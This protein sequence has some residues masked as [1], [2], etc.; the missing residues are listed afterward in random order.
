MINFGLIRSVSLATC[1]LGAIMFATAASAQDAAPPADADV[2]AESSAVAD[3]AAIIVTR[4][5]HRPLRRRRPGLA[6]GDS[7]LGAARSHLAEQYRRLSSRTC[8][9]ISDRPSRPAAASAAIAPPAPSNLRGLGPAATLILLDGQRTTQVP[10]NADN[11]VDV[12]TLVPT[13]MIE[14]IEVVKDGASAIYGSDAVAGV[15]NFITKD[16]FDGFEING[17]IDQFTFSND[18]DRRLELLFGSSVGDRGHFVVSASYLDQDPMLLRDDI[19]SLAGEAYDARWSSPTSYPGVFSVPTRNAAGV[20]T[21]T[22]RTVADPLC[23]QIEGAF[24]S[25]GRLIDGIAERLPNATGATQCRFHFYPEGAAQADIRQF[26]TFGKFTYDILDT[27]K[28]DASMAYTTTRVLTFFTSGAT[29]SFPNLIV[30]GHNPGNIFRAVNSAGVPLYAVSS[31]V[32]AGFS[33]DGAE[34]FLPTRNASGAVVL[35]A[36][37]TNPASGIPFYEDVPVHRPRDRIAGRPADRQ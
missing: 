24:P 18:G 12:N 10:D 26:Q 15:V 6:G 13:I 16:K 37:P 33:R 5:A 3:N 31:G 30:P 14:R 22:R 11:V 2:A 1:S 27:V 28:F 32:S 34:V 25:S 21:T 7:R 36:D 20:L 23:G 8:R 17:R 9:P 4:I 19:P 29:A 35:T